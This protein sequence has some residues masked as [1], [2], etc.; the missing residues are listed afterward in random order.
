MG[1][2]SAGPAPAA[3]IQ[4]VPV[5]RLTEVER[6]ELED[7]GEDLSGDFIDIKLENRQPPVDPAAKE[8]SVVAREMESVVETPAP[9]ASEKLSSQ[10]MQEL[11]NLR[12]ENSRLRKELQDKPDHCP[13]CAW[14]VATA[15]EY[16]PTD[17][18]IREFLESVCAGSIFTKTYEI[19]GGKVKVTFRTRYSCEMEAVKDHV[20]EVSGGQ[21]TEEMFSLTD[22]LVFLTSLKGLKLKDNEKS[23]SELRDLLKQR[24]E[25]MEAGQTA[26]SVAKILRERVAEIPSHIRIV[27]RQKYVEFSAIV[28]HLMTKANDPKYWKGATI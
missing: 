15:V 18:D 9:E 17:E 5:S 19:Y 25:A 22:E 26:K 28:E 20:M 8:R 27:I 4:R 7:Q 21:L 6:K 1:K 2:Q 23:F 12:E 16:E 24:E 10:S 13:R 11:E 14:P 3:G